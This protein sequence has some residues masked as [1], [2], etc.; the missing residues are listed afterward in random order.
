MRL[1]LILVIYI[2]ILAYIA[3]F[4]QPELKI[5]GR[6]TSADGLLTDGIKY[7][8]KD[9][10]GFMWFAYAHGFQRWDGYEAKNYTEYLTDTTLNTSYRYCRPILEDKKGNFFIGSLQNGL[11]KLDRKTNQYIRYLHDPDDSNS[12]AGDG[13]HEMLLDESGDIWIGTFVKGLSR[14]NPETESFRNYLVIDDGKYHV[15]NNIKSIF[16]DSQGILW[17]GT[18]DGLYQF[19]ENT[20]TFIPIATDPILPEYLNSFECIIEDHNGD[21]WFG[22]NWGI[23]RYYRETG[24]WEHILTINPDKPDSDADAKVTCMVDFYNEIRHQIWIASYAGLKVYDIKNGELTHITPKN[25]YPEITNAGHVQYL[26]L[27]DDNILWAS[28][29]GVTLID[30]S[31][32]LYHNPFQVYLLKSYPDSIYDTPA[33]CFYEDDK[34]NIWIGSKADGVYKFDRNLNFIANYKAC[35]W[36]PEESNTDFNNMVWRIYEDPEGRI[37]MSTGPTCLSIFDMETGRFHP[38]D[39]DVGSYTPGRILI[40]PHNVVWLTAHD[41]LHKGNISGDYDLKV[42]LYDNPTLPKVPI[43]WI[44]YDSHDRLWVITRNSGVFCLHPENRDSMIFQRYLHDNYRHRFTI[45]YNA[46]SMIEDDEGNIWFRS[47]KEL[48]KYDPE[49][50]SIVPDTYFNNNFRGYIFSFTRD[51]NGLFWFGVEVGLLMYNPSDT[52]HGRLRSI[53]YRSGIPFTYIERG[54]FFRDSRGFMYQGGPQQRC[55]GFFVFTRTVF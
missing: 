39:V 51:K 32:N 53:D 8:M 42:S 41:G 10:Q 16:R 55:E 23:F 36:T 9:S 34:N 1:K 13:I 11:I 18:A 50:D 15:C 27:D 24:K 4:A 7:T 43:D 14:F 40:D 22:T 17:V 37:W 54:P 19:D 38:I 28:L 44:L 30:L 47:E 12:L 20:E 5:I 21:M 45:E 6:I 25:G 31:N 52:S 33:Y 46:R 48:F 26:Y 29:A 3:S 2:F 49:L 35:D